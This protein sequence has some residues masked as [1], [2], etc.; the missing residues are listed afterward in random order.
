MTNSLR[1]TMHV[2]NAIRVAFLLA[3]GGL[4]YW[5]ISAQSELNQTLARRLAQLETRAATGGAPQIAA[6][7]GSEPQAADV[8]PALALVTA[9]GI[10]TFVLLGNMFAKRLSDPL[11]KAVEFTQAVAAGDLTMRM[12]NPLKGEAGDMID[13]FNE[14]TDSLAD[15]VREVRAASDTVAHAAREIAAGN[16]HLSERTDHQAST[17]EQTAAS[18]EQLAST[19]GENADN[20]KQ[21]QTLAEN[22]ARLATES[23]TSL[24]QVVETMRQIDGGAKK[25][26]DIIGVIDGIAF[27]TNLLALNAAVEA[28][29]AQEHGRGFAVVAA[30]VRQLAQR[31]AQAAK[32]IRALIQQ[33]VQQVQAGN[34][35][36]TAMGAQMHNTLASIQKVAAL[37][38]DIAIATSEQREG[39]DQ[40]AEAVTQLDD[41]AQQNASLVEQ[42]SAAA[43]SLAYQAHT[44]VELVRRFKVQVEPTPAP[45][46]FEPITPT[47]KTTA[48]RK[49]AGGAKTL[50]GAAAA[51]QALPKRDEG[52]WTEF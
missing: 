23:S 36:V 1:T 24:S 45:K 49:P 31:A 18:M 16:A 12:D 52:D 32:E 35:M 7:Q 19:V 43:E 46:V 47:P 25:I 14:M 8:L 10:L 3:V 6:A 15:V 11:A 20:A 39:I 4:G 42:A 44:L 41:L 48:K 37:I 30:E 26:A 40:V 9:F 28:A 5:G 33:S 17:L 21:A 27:Q 13:A 2:A 22:T 38:T 29:R 34:E 51:A 50:R